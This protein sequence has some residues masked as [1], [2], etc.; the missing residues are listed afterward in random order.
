MPHPNTIRSRARL[1]AA[2]V[3]ILPAF[4]LHKGERTVRNWLA[5]GGPREPLMKAAWAKALAHA[6]AKLAKAKP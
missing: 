6:K 1:I 4:N 2:L 5:A 3:L